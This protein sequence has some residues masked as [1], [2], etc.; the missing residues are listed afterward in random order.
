ML[1]GI[2]QMAGQQGPVYEK[3][4]RG[5][6]RSLPRERAWYKAE[7]ARLEREGVDADAPGVVAV[8]ASTLTA[9]VAER[10]NFTRELRGIEREIID[11]G[12]HGE[13]TDRKN[14]CRLWS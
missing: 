2:H 5:R 3:Y 11:G 7:L 1:E 6:L 8:R 13:G 4:L 14:V 9:T 10:T 12:C